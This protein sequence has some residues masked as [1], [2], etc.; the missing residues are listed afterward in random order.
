M[1]N[2][3]IVDDEWLIASTLSEM[4][5]WA[6]KSIHVIG[7]ASNGKEALDWIE[8]HPIDIIITDIQ[9]PD[10]DGLELLQ[11]IYAR[12]PDISVII[13]S[14]YEEF[15]YAHTAMKYKAKGY[16][17]KPIDTDELLHIIDEILLETTNKTGIVDLAKPF[18]QVPEPF[19]STDRPKTYHETLV[20]RAMDYIKQHL[21]QPITLNEVSNQFYL[22][23]HYFGQIFKTV[24]GENFNS[25]LT[26]LRMEKAC[27]LLKSPELRNYD[28]CNHI[29][30]SDVKYFSKLFYRCYK[31]TPKE[32]RERSLKERTEAFVIK[33]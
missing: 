27:E 28:I 14:G 32:Y 11:M 3:L 19:E 12:R 4:D 17:L 5:E 2:M 18:K 6:E 16:V 30:F 13:I 9:M 24:L 1:K 20:I 10:M 8:R 31:I 25:Y 21:D 7:I 15:Q 29:G 33:K 22:T 23:A 26:R